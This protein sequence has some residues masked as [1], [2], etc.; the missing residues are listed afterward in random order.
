[1]SDKWKKTECKNCYQ[2][3]GI[4]REIILSKS[5]TWVHNN[6]IEYTLKCHVWEDCVAEPW[7][8]TES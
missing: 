1:M 7:E 6:P 2:K 5:G 8:E 4:K 3:L